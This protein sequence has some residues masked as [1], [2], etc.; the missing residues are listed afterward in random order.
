ME[1]GSLLNA[2]CK[3]LFGSIRNLARRLAESIRNRLI[4]REALDLA[5]AAS[6]QIRINTS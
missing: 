2:D 1:R 6:I 3:R 5:A 4:P